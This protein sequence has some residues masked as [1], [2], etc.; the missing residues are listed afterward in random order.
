MGSDVR[1]ACV[2]TELVGMYCHFVRVCEG[3][4]VCMA[5]TV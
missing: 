5:Q 1:E 2:R 4:G 3:F